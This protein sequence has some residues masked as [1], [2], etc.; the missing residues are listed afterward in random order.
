MI[1]ILVRHCFYSKVSEKKER[2]QNFNRQELFLTLLQSFK[3]YQNVQLIV[4]LDTAN[5]NQNLHF[6]EEIQKTSTFK[7]IIHKKQLG[8][9]K[10]SFYETLQ[11]IKS[12]NL[13]EEDIV[14]FLEDDYLIDKNKKWIFFIQEGLQFGDY[15][16]LYDHPDKYSFVYKN[17]ISKVYKGPLSHWRT[18]PS[19]TNSY[20]TK[21]KTLLEDFHIHSKYS[22]GNGV[23]NDHE[24]FLTLWNNNKSLVSS[25]PALWSHEEQYMTCTF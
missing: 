21:G 2:P 15:V 3:E 12:Q 18:T 24:K 10:A 5:A 6:T 17:L 9:E 22:E 4:I 1:F 7:F 8:N 25:I 20:A 23:T 16:T 19:T 13:K 11:Y 14:V